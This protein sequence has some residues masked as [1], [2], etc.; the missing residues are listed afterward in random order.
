MNRLTSLI[1]GLV[2]IAALTTATPAEAQQ[3]GRAEV[4]VPRGYEPPPGMCRIWLEGV[5][6]NQ[7]PAPTDCSSAIRKRPANASVV[8][9]DP[10][11]GSSDRT[12]P[13]VRP[14]APDRNTPPATRRESP[15][16][17]ERPSRERP[18]QERP[19]E[20]RPQQ[21]RPQQERREAERRR[22]TEERT[23]PAQQRGRQRTR[24]S[25]PP[26]SGYE[27]ELASARWLDEDLLAALYDPGRLERGGDVGRSA[28]GRATPRTGAGER[29]RSAVGGVGYAPLDWA[30][31]ADGRAL[32]A[33]EVERY[34]RYGA[35]SGG[36]PV[37]VGDI[38]S[39]GAL[40]DDGL[41]RARPG[42][43]YDRNFDGRCDDLSGGADGCYDINRDGR[44]D[45]MRWDYPADRRPG[46]DVY[47]AGRDRARNDGEDAAAWGLCFDRDRDGRCDEPWSDGRRIPQTL[48]EMA[49]AAGLRRGVA[50][51]D[52]ERW[53][54]RTDVSARI[55]DR[56]RDGIPER[57]I[58]L[59]AQGQ[60]VQLWSDR[61]GDGIADRVELY[62]DGLPVQ[63]V[64]R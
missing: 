19:Q 24:P 2:A 28:G 29:G 12:P 20:E 55:T 5:P 63:V 51:Y 23:A 1:I 11:R 47:A 4:R 52:V 30:L 45:D 42:E 36:Q 8:F 31:D 49:A 43:C 6:A 13:V 34:L 37:L 44:C 7:Q 54:R 41:V 48:P 60:V 59:D 25:R 56:D 40:P 16:R 57:V 9:G 17:D 26:D 14:L 21:E 35:R 53:L 38:G 39:L 64:E 58:W 46:R 22:P 15:P 3:R 62:R 10:V 61:D 27:E 33:V 18:Q 32:S 50:S